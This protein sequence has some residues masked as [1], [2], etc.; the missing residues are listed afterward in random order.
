M[1]ATLITCLK[2]EGPFLIEWLA[3]HKAI[4]FRRFIVGAND[5]TDGSHEMLTRLA[6]L[7]EIEYLPFSKSDGVGAQ[8]KF[9][10]NLLATQVISPGEWICWLDLD[11]FLNIHLGN[12]QIDDLLTA[13]ARA[14]GIRLNW[15]IFGADAAQLWPD[16]QLHP[17]FCRCARAD[18]GMVGPYPANRTFKSLYKYVQGMGFWGHGP[19]FNHAHIAEKPVWWNGNGKRIRRT[20]WPYKVEK[21]KE[22]GPGVSYLPGRPTYRWAQI[23]HYATRHPDLVI[24]RRR[25]GRGGAFVPTDH[26]HPWSDD[27]TDRH[28]DAYF[29]R[30][31]RTEDEDRSILR[32]LPAVDAEMA[33]LL[34]DDTVG[35]W[36]S[37]AQTLLRRHLESRERAAD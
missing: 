36:H 5:C 17:T 20:K 33:R 35:H 18:F 1:P 24:L 14:D 2:D 12:G 23:N 8:D 26:R 13:V 19:L 34:A 9:A 25:R 30:Y 37:H 7:G 4:G 3:Y 22:G 6:A 31:N 11:E 21:L 29:A 28:S 15:R 32:H 10:T 16:R 27:F